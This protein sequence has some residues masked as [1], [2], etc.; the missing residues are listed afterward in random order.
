MPFDGDFDERRVW[1][2][3]QGL[4]VDERDALADVPWGGFPFAED[5]TMA[6]TD[7]Q[8]GIAG[9]AAVRGRRGW[10]ERV[11]NGT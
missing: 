7:P 1:T 2:V 11:R 5:V 8:A 3:D 9:A 6:L 10:E 4:T